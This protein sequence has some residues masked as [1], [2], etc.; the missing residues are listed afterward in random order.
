ME[1]KIIGFHLDEE[2]HWVAEL[3]C[4]HNQHVRHDPPLTNRPWVLTE[5]GRKSKL[6]LTLNCTRCDN[7]E[8]PD[9]LVAHEKTPTFNENTIPEGLKNSHATKAGIWGIIH[10]LQGTLIYTIYPQKK[11]YQIAEGTPGIIAP[12][13]L[14]NVTAQGNVQFYIEFF[15]KTPNP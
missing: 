14:H 11:Q 5:N 13:L 4:Y 1:R 8:F 3:D 7:L 15:T 12:T 6:G 10:V 2:N 9:N